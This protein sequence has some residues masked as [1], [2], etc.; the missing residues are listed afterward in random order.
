MELPKKYNNVH[1]A[2]HWLTAFLIV[3]MLV[4]GH[5]S[6]AATPNADAGKIFAL[7]GHMILGSVALVLTLA[8]LYWKVKSARPAYASTGSA[9]MDKLGISVQH[10]LYLLVIIVAASG[11]GLALLTGLPGIVFGSGGALPESFFAFTPRYVH[12]IA[13]KILAGLI[14]LHGVGALYHQFVLKDN[15]FARMWFGKP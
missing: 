1:V 2:L 3:F 4:M 12:G 15:L 8:R 6:L 9:L 14:V 7:R 11:I 5:F 10:T 13:T